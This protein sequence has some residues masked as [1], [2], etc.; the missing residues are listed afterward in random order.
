MPGTVANV[1]LIIV[2]VKLI[3]VSA[4]M[5]RG[6]SRMRRINEDNL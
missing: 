3:I 2:S 5:N 1:E 6:F 4:N